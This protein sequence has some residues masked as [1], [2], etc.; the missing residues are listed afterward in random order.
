MGWPQPATPIQT[1][2]STACGIANDTIKQQRSRA[3]D[4]RFYW[5]RDR[6]QQGHFNIFCRPGPTNLAD[7][8]TKHHPAKHHQAMR[9]VYLHMMKQEEER[10][11]N[12]TIDYA[13]LV[14]Q[15]CIETPVVW[16]RPAH[17]SESPMSQNQRAQAALV[18]M[19]QTAT[20]T[21][22]AN[23]QQTVD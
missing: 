22:T 15:G 5:V 13:L 12:H 4:M 10:A 20:Q 8:F 9:P 11:A 16:A 18:S 17:T 7:Y 1:D 21:Q 2:N 14:L 19:S 3:I 23:P 6:T